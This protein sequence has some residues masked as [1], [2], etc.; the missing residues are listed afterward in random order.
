MGIT[1]L[2][3]IHGRGRHPRLGGAAVS[4]EVRNPLG[5]EST[6]TWSEAQRQVEID[7]KQLGEKRP[8]DDRL[9]RLTITEDLMGRSTV[10]S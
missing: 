9:E 8:R 7:T 3:S 4:T 5:R 1:V 2:P 6:L 10:A